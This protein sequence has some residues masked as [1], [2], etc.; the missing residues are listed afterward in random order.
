MR[1]EFR[2]GRRE[3]RRACRQPVTCQ[4]V[5]AFDQLGGLAEIGGSGLVTT[6][7][8]RRARKRNSLNDKGVVQLPNERNEAPFDVL[9]IGAIGR[10]VG[11]Q[12]FFRQGAADVAGAD[13]RE[14]RDVAHRHALQHVPGLDQEVGRIDGVPNDRVGSP[15]LQAPVSGDEAEGAA[16]GEQ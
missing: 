13:E 4:A 10:R 7:V 14:D 16:K 5:R 3:L 8:L 15:C 12:P 1:C 2:R 9:L 6:G 11:E